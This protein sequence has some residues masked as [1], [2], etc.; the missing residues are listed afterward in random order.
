ME[1]YLKENKTETEENKCEKE[2]KRPLKFK[3][4][5]L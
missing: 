1:S 2:F 4:I 3:I 5:R